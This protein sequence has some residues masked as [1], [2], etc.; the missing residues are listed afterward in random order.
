[1]LFGFQAVFRLFNKH[2]YL[3]LGRAFVEKQDLVSPVLLLD[4]FWNKNSFECIP[5]FADFSIPS[6]IGTKFSVKESKRKLVF[7]SPHGTIGEVISVLENDEFGCKEA[8]KNWRNLLNLPKN[9]FKRD[10]ECLYFNY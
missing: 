8:I 5:K 2:G 7:I 4:F 3:R 9:I 10:F 1:M 6:F